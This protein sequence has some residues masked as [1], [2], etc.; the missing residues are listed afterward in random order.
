MKKTVAHQSSPVN[1]GAILHISATMG[2][3]P[4]VMNGATDMVCFQTTPV[5]IPETLTVDQIHAQEHPAYVKRET[6]LTV[7]QVVNATQGTVYP[8]SSSPQFTARSGL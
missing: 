3:T 8:I 7:L 4:A 6:S 1:C 2:T 5:H